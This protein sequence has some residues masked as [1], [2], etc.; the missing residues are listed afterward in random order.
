MGITAENSVFAMD[1]LELERS[2]V[3]DSHALFHFLFH[4]S[5]NPYLTNYFTSCLCLDYRPHHY[6]KLSSSPTYCQTVKCYSTQLTC[7]RCSS[8]FIVFP[9]SNPCV[10]MRLLILYYYVYCFLCL[11]ACSFCWLHIHSF[12]LCFVQGNIYHL[13]SLQNLLSAVCSLCTWV[14]QHTSKNPS[15]T[16]PPITVWSPAERRSTT[17][18]NSP[19]QATKQTCQVHAST[20]SAR[21]AKSPTHAADFSRHW[22]LLAVLAISHGGDSRPTQTSSWNSSLDVLLGRV[23]EE[24]VN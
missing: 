4:F 5:N 17:Q 14:V 7:Q 2:F 21:P 15:K 12:Q 24:G 19:L 6:L 11:T 13:I 9:W 18:I 22:S 16:N 23:A 20:A 8:M 3:T 1:S 10:F